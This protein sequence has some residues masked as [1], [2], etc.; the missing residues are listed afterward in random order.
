M[1]MGKIWVLILGASLAFGSACKRQ[2]APTEHPTRT[3]SGPAHEIIAP[4]NEQ[5]I[6]PG[7][8]Q[9]AG[10]VVY[11]DSTPAAFVKVTILGTNLQTIQ[12]SAT[13]SDGH[14]FF[15]DLGPGPLIVE[16]NKNFTVVGNTVVFTGGV[17]NRSGSASVSAGDTNV[18]VHIYGGLP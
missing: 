11:G 16:A 18:V 5:I 14:F 8:Q 13:D 9:V 10:V 1:K 6:G 12:E 3:N 2:A 4:T 17:P 7:N 15:S